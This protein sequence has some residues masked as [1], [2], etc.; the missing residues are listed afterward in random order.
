VSSECHCFGHDVSR[1][2]SSSA[3]SPAAGQAPSVRPVRVNSLL[4]VHRY[5]TRD[6]MRHDYIRGILIYDGTVH[7]WRVAS[8]S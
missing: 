3:L 8:Y 2:L 1:C 5:E 7:W 6:A 4:F